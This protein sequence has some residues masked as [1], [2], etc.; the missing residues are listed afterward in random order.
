MYDL[1][2]AKV[3]SVVI[4]IANDVARL[5]VRERYRSTNVLESVLTI[6]QLDAVLGVHLSDELYAIDTSRKAVS[7]IFVRRAQIIE[8]C[9]RESL[10]VVEYRVAFESLPVFSIRESK[11]SLLYDF[12]LGLLD[13][14]SLEICC[15][16]Y[17]TVYS[18]IL[19]K[20]IMNALLAF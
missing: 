11:R 7:A 2:I 6:R 17:L 18:T 8:G 5:R 12:R 1:V 9:L 20:Y 10:S 13:C 19:S 3:N 4:A 14:L 15:L 16:D